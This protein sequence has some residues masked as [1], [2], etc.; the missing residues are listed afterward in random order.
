MNVSEFIDRL[1]ILYFKLLAKILIKKL[2]NMDVAQ[3]RKILLSKGFVMVEYEEKD[4]TQKRV[5]RHKNGMKITDRHTS[6]V[7]YDHFNTC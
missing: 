5:Y 1:Y 4:E 6:R 3:R 2:L 7:G